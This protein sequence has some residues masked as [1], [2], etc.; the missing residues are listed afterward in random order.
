MGRIPICV[1]LSV[2][3]AL[4]AAPAWGA[5]TGAQGTVVDRGLHR[6]WR[7]ER[8]CTHP[9]RPARLVETPW[10]DMAAQAPAGSS[11]AAAAP[12]IRP[13][14]R[15]TVFREDAGTEVC[16]AGVALEGGRLGDT[17]L[18]KAG[19]SRATLRGVVRSPG[20]VELGSGKRWH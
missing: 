20:A 3:L 8:D 9:E 14:M 4:A 11:R 16:L 17:I 10:R 1:T 5:C 12:V 18:V 7:I 13:G 6:V 15:V 2:V 19:L